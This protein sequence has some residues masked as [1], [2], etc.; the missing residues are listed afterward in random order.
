MSLNVR[1]SFGLSYTK[2]ELADLKLSEPAITDGEFSLTASV[3]VTNTGSVAGSEI[4]QLY[5][6]LP[7]TSDLTHPPLQLKAFAKVYDLQP[8]KNERV[9]LS[10]D[11]Y[12]VS[13][14]ESR[15]NTWAV[16]K[17]EYLIQVGTSSD[18][19][20]LSSKFVLSKGFEWRGI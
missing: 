16:G 15:F 14:W 17:G 12:A 13:Y 8:G 19:L 3:S 1:R 5:V 4:V 6:S 10:L 20:L 18:N 2:F 11:K 7:L 9:E